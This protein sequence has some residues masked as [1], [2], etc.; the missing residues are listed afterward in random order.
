MK[1]TDSIEREIKTNGRITLYWIF[2]RIF[3]F[4]LLSFL[5]FLHL[6]YSMDR[7]DE[8]RNANDGRRPL[9]LRFFS[10][11]STLIDRYIATVSHSIR[12]LLVTRLYVDAM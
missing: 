1:P 2:V 12:L 5:F 6:L 4:F 11:Y 9:F 7:D 3:I 8:S 10:T